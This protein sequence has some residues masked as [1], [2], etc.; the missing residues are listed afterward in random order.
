M[1]QDLFIGVDVSKNWLDIHHPNQPPVRIQ[2]NPAA[3]RRF[4]RACRRGGAWVIF[5]ATGG[6][7]RALR[8]A[9]ERVEAKFSRVNPRQARDFARAMGVIGKTDRVDARMLAEFG[10]RLRPKQTMPVAPQRRVLQTLVTRRR[11]LVE[12]RKQEATRLKQTHGNV[13]RA[14]IRSLV[15]I[16]DRRIQKFEAQ[17]ATLITTNQDLA[18]TARR[19]QTVPGVG[20]IVAATLLADLPELGRLDRRRIAALAGLAPVARDSGQIKGRRMIRGGRSTVRSML[21]IAALHASRFCATF[22]EF[23][24]R[25][26]DAGKPIKVVLTATAHKLLGVL[27]AMVA[28]STDFQLDPAG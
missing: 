10:A 14:D 2:N 24:H 18:D 9:L 4:V 12:M 13:A 19:L 23:R 20:L 5:E 11:Q 3:M 7:D 21:Y 27:N 6:Y 26:T 1:M 8:D 17:I 22:K 28:S 16:L 25:L 15:A